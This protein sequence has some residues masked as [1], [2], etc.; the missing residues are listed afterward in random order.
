MLIL[1]LESSC[2]E[3]A[4]ALVTGDRRI[5]AHKLAGQEAAHAPY[6]GVVPEIA[7]RAHVEVLAPLV[8]AALAE[9]GVTLAEVDAIAA[10][11]GPG[12]IGGVMVG[13]VTG[14]ALAHAAG[15]P[16]V[17]V[18]HLE[19]HALSPRLA[20][21][22]LDFP[23]LLLLVSGGHC[24]L[25]LVEGVGRYRR[26]ATTIDDAAGE[27]FDK[28][29]KILGLGFPG[30]PAVERAAALGQPIVPLPRPLFGSAEPHFSF[31]GLKSAVLRAYEAGTW[32]TEDIAASFQQAAVD[33]LVDRTRRQLGEIDATALVVAGG[34]AA[35]GAVRAALE[36]LA[37]DYDLPFAVP[38][39]WLCTDNAAMI[40]WAGAERFAAGF[41]DPL[42]TVARPRW[43]LDPDAEKV[44]G[45]GVKA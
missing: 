3:T 10:T 19:G 15:K 7:A 26:L 31:A 30:G 4:A 28:T 9:A 38:P 27:A 8:E 20:D 12:L 22:A 6:G 1:G 29:A 13:L 42:D 37:G 44:R 17:A 39:Q 2:D 32:A 24:Q 11:A 43:P 5:L 34:V 25:L 23:Y 36:S 41:S 14:K 18:N 35:N 16:L 21:P 40:A 33:C 45:A